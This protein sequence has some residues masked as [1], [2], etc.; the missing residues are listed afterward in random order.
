MKKIQ[1]TQLIRLFVEHIQKYL[2]TKVHAQHFDA[3][4]HQ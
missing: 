4:M 3:N 2:L 1:L